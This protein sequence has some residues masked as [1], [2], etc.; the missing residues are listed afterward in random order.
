[1]SRRGAPTSRRARQ[2]RCPGMRPLASCASQTQCIAAFAF[3]WGWKWEK[4]GTWYGLFNEWTA[5]SENISSSVCPV[6]ESEV[7]SAL[8]K[9]WTGQDKS[10]KAPSI[11]SVAVDG[12]QLEQAAFT[13]DQSEVTLVVNA[14]Q[15]DGNPLTGIWVV[16]EE[17]VSEAVGGVH[18]D[19]NPLLE[20]LFP[21]SPEKK[22]G[23]GLSVILNTSTLKISGNYRLYVFVREDPAFCS[24][25]NA[26]CPNHEAYAS[27]AFRICHDALPGEQ[28]YSQVRYAMEKDLQANPDRYPGATTSSSFSEVQMVMAQLQLGDCPHPCGTP[29]WCH[30]T[31]PGEACY[32]YIQWLLKNNNTE[33][34]PEALHG[35]KSIKGAQRAI[36][37]FMPGICPRPCEGVGLQCEPNCEDTPDETGIEETSR[38]MGQQFPL[39]T[40]VQSEVKKH[41]KVLWQ[42][43]QI[44]DFEKDGVSKLIL[45]GPRSDEEAMKKMGQDVMVMVYLSCLLVITESFAAMELGQSI[46]ITGGKY[47]GKAAVIEGITQ[48]MLKVKLADSDQKGSIRKAIARLVAPVDRARRCYKKAGFRCKSSSDASWGCHLASKWQ[49]WSKVHKHADKTTQVTQK[50]RVPQ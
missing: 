34:G 45:D 8:Q 19:T 22:S 7:L 50:A 30:S 23:V 35:K 16:T 37:E 20:D 48:K 27:M 49:R 33:N 29:I 24:A 38:G 36:H 5:V 46:S 1:M 18:E 40:M 32:D 10:T 11:H 9:C 39:D 13:V 44:Q 4:T 31:E 21:D 26:E 2:R 14:T 6:C 12:K 25:G 28:C 15:Q 43:G 17:I 41:W 42:H 3:V 47:V